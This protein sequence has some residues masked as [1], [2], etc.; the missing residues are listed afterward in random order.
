MGSLGGQESHLNRQACH[1]PSCPSALTA[2]DQAPPV[3]RQ[4]IKLQPCLARCSNLGMLS[5]TSPQTLRKGTL[6]SIAGSRIAGPSS[7]PILLIT[8]RFAP[9]SLAGFR[10]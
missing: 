2:P 6:T 10:C 5:Q 3:A 9:L 4:H 8:L 7:S 1:L